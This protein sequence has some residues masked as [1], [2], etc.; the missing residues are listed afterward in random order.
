MPNATTIAPY[1]IHVYQ[2]NSVNTNGPL[3]PRLQ[4]T[5]SINSIASDGSPS[6]SP[7]FDGKNIYG[8]SKL[9][10]QSLENLPQPNV[11][12]F[13]ANPF[14][15]EGRKK[16]KMNKKLMSSK[17][18]SV[19]DK[20]GLI[21]QNINSPIHIN[22]LSSAS[23]STISA[24]THRG[25]SDALAQRKIQT[26][27]GR[28]IPIEIEDI[29][30]DPQFSER[31]VE[32]I[33]SQPLLQPKQVIR[34]SKSMPIS[35]HSTGINGHQNLDYRLSQEIQ[36]HSFDFQQQVKEGRISPE[37]AVAKTISQMI[38]E[39]SK[40][41]KE[42]LNLQKSLFDENN[43]S[44][45]QM[46]G[47]KEVLNLIN[48]NL[49]GELSRR[50]SALVPEHREI[51]R[52]VEIK[53]L[54][55]N[56]P[57]PDQ[58]QNPTGSGFDPHSNPRELTR[59]PTYE[60]IDNYTL[61]ENPPPELSPKQFHNVSVG[62]P[63]LP[64]LNMFPQRKI[65]NPSRNGD[66]A[67]SIFTE[68]FMSETNSMMTAQRRDVESKLDYQTR[69][70][71]PCLER[72]ESGKSVQFKELDEYDNGTNGIPSH[73]KHLHMKPARSIL[74][75]KSIHTTLA[76]SRSMDHS[77]VPPRAPN[78]G[79]T[80]RK[81]TPLDPSNSRDLN[82][83]RVISND[84]ISSNGSELNLDEKVKL[85]YQIELIRSGSSGNPPQTTPKHSTPKNLE[86]QDLNKIFNQL[87]VT[88]LQD[89]APPVKPRCAIT[90][91]MNMRGF[92][93]IADYTST[94]PVS[95]KNSK[96]SL[97]SNV[98]NVTRIDLETASRKES[99]PHTEAQNGAQASNYTGC[100]VLNQQLHENKARL[101]EIFSPRDRTS[102]SPHDI[103]SRR[104]SYGARSDY[105]FSAPQKINA[106]GPSRLSLDA[107]ALHSL[108]E[109]IYDTHDL[110]T[111]TDNRTA[112]NYEPGTIFTSHFQ[113]T[114]SQNTRKDF[115][116]RI[117]S[118]FTLT[119][120][121][122]GDSRDENLNQSMNLTTDLGPDDAISYA[123]S[124]I[125]NYQE[126]EVDMSNHLHADL[127]SPDRLEYAGHHHQPHPMHEYQ[128]DHSSVSPKN[129]EN[130]KSY[131]EEMSRH[132]SS[133]TDQSFETRRIRTGYRE[134]YGMSDQSRVISSDLYTVDQSHGELKSFPSKE[135]N[136]K[137][138]KWFDRT[139]SSNSR[140]LHDQQNHK[141]R[142]TG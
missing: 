103:A 24:P 94:A 62:P 97:N 63:K 136:S 111:P 88:N 76:S 107:R 68:E 17:S 32:A 13:C 131:P 14:T 66:R 95:R 135:S 47:N 89:P 33:L 5:N 46:L 98:T 59:S 117:Q 39:K 110:V 31:E 74:S 2:S 60:T 130:L 8:K 79:S 38:I 42:I 116:D 84:Y 104:S 11:A 3:E 67:Y 115:L 77:P 65:I 4:H 58:S 81:R 35:S 128:N 43:K 140:K 10:H 80:V 41:S 16:L 82:I 127:A 109:D 129:H 123:A 121:T 45:A 83:D 19:Y 96:K 28:D 55:K 61:G 132:T 73:E 44:L 48:H 92:S 6:P 139:M 138:K 30:N 90:G 75:R 134:N 112:T 91:S 125:K 78:R 15:K 57:P 37:T 133:R 71:T 101:R 108:E 21:K 69:D 34:N 137:S 56:E 51:N 72:L 64:R 9:E 7:G 20:K 27:R 18:L 1:G 25:N 23:P 113:S 126:S 36:S 99:G 49:D 22:I 106:H 142:N 29:R 122:L 26:Y 141:I 102:F 93:P 114:C 54:R 118:N 119:S 124:D 70:N 12:C 100:P 105:Q 85:A 40:S 50:N 87:S 52:S 86:A 120:H 53:Y